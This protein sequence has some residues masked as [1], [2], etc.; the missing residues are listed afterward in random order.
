MNKEAK[1]QRKQGGQQ[2]NEKSGG[3]WALT[4]QKMKKMDL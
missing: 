1:N 3:Q 4:S 2:L